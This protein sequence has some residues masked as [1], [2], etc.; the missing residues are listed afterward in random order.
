MASKIE[1]AR[2]ANAGGAELVIVSGQHPHPL[3]RLAEGGCGTVFEA[4]N[5][6]TARK[7]WLA[8]RLTV[9]GRV[10]VDAGAER[11]LRKGASLLPAGAHS[12]SGKFLRGDVIDFVGPDGETIARG[13]AEYD[14]DDAARICGVKSDA[15]EGVLGYAPR[16]VLV[17]RDH[18]VIL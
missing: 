4:G 16:P 8:G 11:A 10:M 1:A 3:A 15:L 9:K 14:A 18:M 2:I 6:A 13:L 12:T 5:A 7:A 17:H